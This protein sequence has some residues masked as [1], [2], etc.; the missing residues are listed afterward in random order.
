MNSLCKQV[1]S[2]EQKLDAIQTFP[3][4]PTKSDIIQLL[5]IKKSDSL[6]NDEKFQASVKEA[7]DPRK[8]AV[9]SKN[10]KTVGG[11]NIITIF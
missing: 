3:A 10:L 7:Q 2:L 6:T 11:N 8:A 5:D 1:A 4:S 9:I